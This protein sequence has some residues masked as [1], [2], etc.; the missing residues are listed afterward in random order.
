MKN[1]AQRTQRKAKSAKV[2]E[3][4]IYFCVLCL[5]L[6]SLRETFYSIPFS[7][8]YSAIC[9]AFVAAPFLRLSETIHIFNV[10]S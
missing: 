10:R 5:P 8:R 9:T 7:K 3:I 1:F 2:K 4:N 6:R